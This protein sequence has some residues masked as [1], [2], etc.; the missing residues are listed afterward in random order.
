MLFRLP[1]RRRLIFCTLEAA[2]LT[3]A[4]SQVASVVERNRAQLDRKGFKLVGVEERERKST[5]FAEWAM[6]LP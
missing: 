3:E 5:D 6:A 4:K 1:R 2:S